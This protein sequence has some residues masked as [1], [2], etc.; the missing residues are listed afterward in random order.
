MP[1]AVNRLIG[2]IV[3]NSSVSGQRTGTFQKKFA[4]VYLS[5]VAVRLI[6]ERCF[7]GA[8]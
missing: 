2:S 6:R 3:S 7:C 1:G 4:A 5:R 8:I